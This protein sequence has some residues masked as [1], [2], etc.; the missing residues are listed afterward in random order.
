MN[1]WGDYRALESK[2]NPTAIN[3]LLSVLFLSLRNSE[4][5]TL[6]KCPLHHRK[7]IVLKIPLFVNP[8]KW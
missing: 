4:N 8:S 6:L 1:K 7:L 2:G 3:H 5:M